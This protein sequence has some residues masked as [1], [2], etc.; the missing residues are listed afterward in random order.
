MRVYFF[1]L[2]MLLRIP[3]FSVNNQNID[4]VVI[5]YAA[6][7]IITDIGIDCT[8]YERSIDYQEITKTDSIS[9]FLLLNELDQLEMSQ[10]RGEDIR[11]KLEF[12]NSGSIILSCCIGNFLTKKGSS[13]YYTSSTLKK[14]IDDIVSSQTNIK[15]NRVLKYWDSTP[16]VQKI[17]EYLCSQSERLYRGLIFSEDLCFTV[18]CNVGEGGKTL[19]TRFTKNKKGKGKDLPT[20]IISVIQNI[21]FNEITW[22]IPKECP[23]QWI[24]IN[25]T[26]KSNWNRKNDVDSPVMTE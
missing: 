9:I 17:K 22:D 8:N 3:V 4:S 14:V 24:S 15:K 1:I 21:L 26:I 2:F 16:S 25:L 10:N 11:C 20:Q 7:N 12:Y 23:P 6:W 13:Y 19:A 5:K 18:F